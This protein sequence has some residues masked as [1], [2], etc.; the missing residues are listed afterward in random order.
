MTCHWKYNLTSLIRAVA[1]GFACSWMA[2]GQRA[3]AGPLIEPYGGYLLGQHSPKDTA[4]HGSHT[5]GALMGARLG[6]G[7]LGVHLAADGSLMTGGSM[8]AS[9][10][11]ATIN[12]SNLGGALMFD[13]PFIPRFWVGYGYH[14]MFV[15]R[16]DPGVY[17]NYKLV[18]EYFKAGLGFS[19]F[20]FVSF[21]LEYMNF[22]YSRGRFSG[23]SLDRRVLPVVSEYGDFRADHQAV[24]ASLSLPLGW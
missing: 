22:A 7:L 20:P 1:V 21:N 19:V 17:D 8:T 24:V 11:S 18:G 6:M 16:R 14:E 10:S 2:F 12:M 3:I 5:S 15:G 9:P 13:L 4:T 23:G